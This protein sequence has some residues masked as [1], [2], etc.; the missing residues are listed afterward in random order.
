MSLQLRGHVVMG[1]MVA[2]IVLANLTATGV[3][4]GVS[5]RMFTVLPAIAL[6]YYL[7]IWLR[8]TMADQ[9]TGGYRMARAYLHAGTIL[10]VALLQFELGSA[11]AAAGWAAM[12]AGLLAL[13]LRMGDADLRAQAYVLALLAFVR[14]WTGT[15]EIPE[16][17]TGAPGRLATAA[18]VVGS[19]YL[20][21][22]LLA[23][24]AVA[25]PAVPPL[26]ATLV[27]RADHCAGPAF[28]VAATFL[29]ASLL[30]HE[31]S[32]GL[33]TVAWAVQ[34]TALLGA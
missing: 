22:R 29:L 27:A 9:A 32:A 19:F 33:L 18:L 2:R 6:L 31:M 26:A 25:G 7:S 11:V 8:G 10:T 24:G 17:L 23:R 21:Q 5:H 3:T 15:F 1:L 16:S 14:A 4:A 30:F 20:A 34:G 12:A 13:G 28:S